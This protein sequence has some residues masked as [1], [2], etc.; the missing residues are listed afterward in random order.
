[1]FKNKT[2]W[3]LHNV[4]AIVFWLT[5]LAFIASGQTERRLVLV[6]AIIFG[7]HVLELPVAFRVLRGRNLSSLKIFTMTM[8]FGYT[9]WVPVRV[10]A[11]SG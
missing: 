6:A 2:F 5:A 4:V 7:L 1:M 9:W 11:Y 3:L 8:L 10:G